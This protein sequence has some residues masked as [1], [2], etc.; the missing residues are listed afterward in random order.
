[1]GWFRAGKVDKLVRSSKLRA[2][3]LRN[4]YVMAGGIQI[5]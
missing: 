2:N 3:K 4:I 1:M 5:T